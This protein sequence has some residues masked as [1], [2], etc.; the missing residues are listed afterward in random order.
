MH[1]LQIVGKQPQEKA[2][3][4]SNEERKLKEWGKRQKQR[5]LAE[6]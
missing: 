4:C 3:A 2:V 5:V 1:W 6:N